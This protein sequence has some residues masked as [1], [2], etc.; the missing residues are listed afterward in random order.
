[1]DIEYETISAIGITI[2]TDLLFKK[3]K[4]NPKFKKDLMLHMNDNGEVDGLYITIRKN[5]TH[6]KIKEKEWSKL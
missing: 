3:L 2:P 4:I 5:E 6:G 1:M